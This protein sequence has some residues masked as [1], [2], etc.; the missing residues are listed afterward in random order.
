VSFTVSPPPPLNAYG[1]QGEPAYSSANPPPATTTTPT[2]APPP[3]AGGTSLNFTPSPG[4]Q[5]DSEVINA[6]RVFQSA[7]KDVQQADAQAGQLYN[8]FIRAQSDPTDY[9][10][11][12]KKAAGQA[13][14]TALRALSSAMTARENAAAKMQ[15][16]SEAAASREKTP[17]IRQ[18]YLAHAEQANAAAAVSNAQVKALDAKTP[19]EVAQANAAANEANARASSLNLLTPA[20]AAQANQQ[21]NLYGAQALQIKTLLPSLETKSEAEARIAAAQAGV[22]PQ[23][24]QAAVDK[25]QADVDKAR[26]DTEEVRRR[27]AGMPTGEQA[28]AAIDLGLK[29]K[30]ADL[31]AK[32]LQLEQARQLMPIAV[33]QAGAT[34]AATQAGTA[35]TLAAIGQKTLGPLYGIGDQ[36]SKYRDMIATG[37]LSP[38]DADTALNTYLNTQVTGA[39][40]F[41]IGSE[42]N[43]YAEALRQQDI[44][45]AQNRLNAA[46]AY[47]SGTLGQF[48]QLAAGAGPGFGQQM[49]AGF[50]AALNAGR[51]FFG[52]MGGMTTP[53]SAPSA[54]SQAPVVH[55]NIGGGQPTSAPQPP[56]VTPQLPAAPPALPGLPPAPTPADLSAAAGIPIF[57]GPSAQPYS[58]TPETAEAAQARLGAVGAGGGGEGAQDPWQAH[59]DRWSNELDSGAVTAPGQ[60]QEAQG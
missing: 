12:K 4:G 8:D 10:G 14:D 27:V 3:A 38:Q 44:S 2:T 11:E 58:Y 36:I 47:A 6:D 20:Q 39:T 23:A 59:M 26:A 55:I 46:Q 21:A 19:A 40:P 60:P 49:A 50:Q 29:D 32:Q 57:G 17:E 33:S 30:E 24:A 53:P 41:Q 37:Q 28:Q 43:R 31:Q 35:A 25:A 1:T 48:G 56:E 15:A 9:S 7:D 54:V 51:Q 5:L 18:Y 16:A 13:Y 45:L 34:V 42:Q 22:A 52:Q